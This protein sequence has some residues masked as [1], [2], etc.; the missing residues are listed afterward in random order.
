[1][2]L[3]FRRIGAFIVAVLTYVLISPYLGL[4]ETLAVLGVSS[5]LIFAFTTSG[6]NKSLYRAL[7]PREHRDLLFHLI[8]PIAAFAVSDIATFVAFIGG[9]PET[10]AAVMGMLVFF[11][12]MI[13]LSYKVFPNKVAPRMP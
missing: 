6:F 10:M 5:A 8:A 2:Q 11:A 3:D 9:V 7:R 4:L 13:W 12:I 1:M